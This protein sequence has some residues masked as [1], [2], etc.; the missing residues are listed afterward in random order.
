MEVQEITFNYFARPHPRDL[1]I[2][3]CDDDDGHTKKI[4]LSMFQNLLWVYGMAW[5]SVRFPCLKF[6][7]S[8]PLYTSKVLE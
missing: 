4:L 2:F 3:L 1:N 7:P 8:P 5:M 6:C